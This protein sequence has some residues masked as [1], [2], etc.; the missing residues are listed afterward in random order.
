MGTPDHQRLPR[1]RARPRIPARAS[2]GD[3]RAARRQRIQPGQPARHAQRGQFLTPTTDTS[4]TRMTV[5]ILRTADAWWVQTPTGAAQVTTTASTTRE[6][7]ANPAAIE[8]DAH[9]RATV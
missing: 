4:R 6:V 3:R 7:L 5:S 1:H 2:L 8:A 9:R